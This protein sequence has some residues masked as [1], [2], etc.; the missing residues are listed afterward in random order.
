MMLG[1]AP[2]QASAQVISRPPDARSADSTPGPTASTRTVDIELTGTLGHQR[3]VFSP[4]FDADALREGWSQG[5]DLI[6]GAEGPDG[7]V[8]VMA[9]R[10]E[11]AVQHVS[12]NTA[13]WP[14][15]YVT[16]YWDDPD[17]VIT[18]VFGGPS[19]WSVIMS[20]VESVYVPSAQRSLENWG[21]TS[22]S[23]RLHGEWPQDVIRELWAEDM[24]VTEIAHGPGGWV[25]VFSSETH[26]GAQ[27]WDGTDDPGA[28][29]RD[30]WNDGY[31]ITDI[32]HDGSQW[33]IVATK[34][35]GIGAQRWASS[36]TFP[37]EEIRE[38]WYDGMHVQAMDYG[39]GHWY[40]VFSQR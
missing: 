12:Y 29:I 30:R 16:Q 37:E 11:R 20:R 27:G 19:G 15:D 22:Q 8:L 39:D 35:A 13:E 28:K 9:R 23:T 31:S 34:N 10:R 2:A 25:L 17:H 6:T 40:V 3:V 18:G 24:D 33:Y 21:W 26:W 14:S 38:A 1:C 5:L 32:A 36:E 4:D 7:Q